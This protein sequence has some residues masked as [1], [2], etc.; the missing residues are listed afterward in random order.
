MNFLVFLIYYIIIDNNTF[1]KTLEKHIVSSSSSHCYFLFH[2]KPKAV[3]A[4]SC[5]LKKPIETH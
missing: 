5:S 2:N 1:H 3:T 4:T